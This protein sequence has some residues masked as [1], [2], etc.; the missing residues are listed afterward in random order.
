MFSLIYSYLFINNLYHKKINNKKRLILSTLI[1]LIIYYSLILTSINKI[2][3][4]YIINIIYYKILLDDKYINYY[5]VSLFSLLGLI[6]SN[7]KIIIL[8]YLIIIYILK[9]QIL[10]LINYLN[11]H[12]KI[13]FFSIGLSYLIILIRVLI[14]SI[15]M[16]KLSNLIILL[17][18]NTL[19]IINEEKTIKLNRLIYK[20]QQLKIYSKNNE[21]IITNYKS[22]LHENKNQLIIIKSMLPNELEKLE[23]Y[24]DNLIRYKINLSNK[25]ISY[26]KYIPLSEI[27]NFINYKLLQLTET[28][29]II[30]IYISKELEK[31]KGEQIDI[32]NLDEFYTILGILLDNIIDSI[33]E[34]T[35]KLVSINVYIE[36]NITNIELANTYQNYIDLK[37]LN[38]YGYTTKG[39]NHGTGLYLVNKIIKNNKIFELNTRIDNKFFVQHLKIKHPKSHLK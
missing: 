24:L 2:F 21:D 10:N 17:T 37:K 29:A 39:N 6:I 5:L 19:I 8:I 18:I 27:K 16:T 38:K 25:W 23:Q 33:K 1:Y 32:I 11:N 7:N 22:L 26:L 4:I 14:I 34:Q 30:E 13:L 36:E 28:G 35:E 15:S 31:I 9:K 20:Y 3:I 12:K